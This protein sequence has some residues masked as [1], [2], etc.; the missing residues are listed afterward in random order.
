MNKFKEYLRAT[1][2][3]VRAQELR[4]CVLVCHCNMGQEC[5]GDVL[6]EL[7]DIRG[8]AHEIRGLDEV[9]VNQDPVRQE[10]LGAIIDEDSTAEGEVGPDRSVAPVLRG[11]AAHP[12]QVLQQYEVGRGPPRVASHMGKTKLFAD[13]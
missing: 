9:L 1:G 13:G 6:A 12:P 10:D 8:E 3:D 2:L 7:A 4:G 11:P 5:H